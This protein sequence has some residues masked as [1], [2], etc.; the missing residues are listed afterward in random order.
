MKNCLKA[1]NYL[2]K[3]SVKDD[4]KNHD[5]DHAQSYRRGNCNDKMRKP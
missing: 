3:P 5:R 2:S 1:A 4:L